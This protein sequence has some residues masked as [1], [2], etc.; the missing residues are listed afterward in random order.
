V[1]NIVM[2]CH[3]RFRL[4]EQALKSLDAHTDRSSYNLVLVDD[5]SKDFRVGKLLAKWAERSNVAVVNVLN[6]GHVLAQL[7]NLGVA[8]SEQFFGQGKWLYLSDSDV[9]FA[10][11]WLDRLTL[12]A[13]RTESL[14]FALWG[15][16]VHPF[17]KGPYW[18]GQSPIVLMD[19]EDNI[20]PV[21]V[22]DGPSWLMR[23]DTWT[24]HG[25][26]DRQSAAG[27]CQSE[28]YPFCERLRSAKRKIAAIEPPVVEHTGITQSNGKLAPGA[29]ERI[30]R[31]LEGILYE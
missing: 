4:L 20:H 13:A 31:K 22:L 1:T 18:H 17:H 26:L 30:A 29:A 6:S 25:G 27:P 23:W 16:Q 14:N 28:E 10:P 21:D 2:L 15:G 19:S 11:G 3:E 7:K 9:W 12:L 5:G 8:A 24:D